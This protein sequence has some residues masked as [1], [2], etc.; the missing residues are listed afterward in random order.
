M[1][2][3]MTA[4]FLAAASGL[5]VLAEDSTVTIDTAAASS[6]AT[7]ITTAM[8]TLY[9]GPVKNLALTVGGLAFTVFLIVLMF[10]LARRMGK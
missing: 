2:K 9:N 7:A 3:L 4:A 10:R 8:T 1:R 5:P 6:A